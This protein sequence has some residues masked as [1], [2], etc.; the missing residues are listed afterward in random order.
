MII[1]DEIDLISFFEDEG[2]R[3][4]N[5]FFYILLQIRTM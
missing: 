3:V 5:T 2:D 1:P 4:D